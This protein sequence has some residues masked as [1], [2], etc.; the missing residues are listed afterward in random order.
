MVVFLRCASLK[1]T[2]RNPY[3]DIASKK[4]DFR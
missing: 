1:A 2:L 4:E 3:I